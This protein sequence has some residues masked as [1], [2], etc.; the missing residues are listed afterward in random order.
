MPRAKKSRKQGRRCVECV[1][2]HAGRSIRDMMD[3]FCESGKDMWEHTMTKGCIDMIK[4]SRLDACTVLGTCARRG[5]QQSDK[6]NS[7]QKVGL[8]CTY[9]DETWKIH[10][11]LQDTQ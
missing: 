1:L 3:S 5:R 4:E 11:K 6:H 7:H 8:C 2:S 10:V 9:V